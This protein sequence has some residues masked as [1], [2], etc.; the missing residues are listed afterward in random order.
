MVLVAAIGAGLS[1]TA[2]ARELDYVHEEIE[3]EIK[4]KL[5][6]IVEARVADAIA[7]QVSARI[8]RA[9]EIDVDTTLEIELE[10]PTVADDE[11]VTG[12]QPAIAPPPAPVIRQKT[13]VRGKLHPDALLPEIDLV[14][15]DRVTERQFDAIEDELEFALDLI[16]DDEGNSAI[17]EQWLVLSDKPSLQALE[18]QGYIVSNLEELDGLGYVLGVI[19]APGTFDPA[20]D[21]AAAVQILNSLT[22]AVD[23]NHVYMPQRGAPGPLKSFPASIADYET[24]IKPAWPRVGM[25]DSNIDATHPVFNS[26][27]ISEETFIPK[28][29][30]NTTQHGTAIASILI[31]DSSDYRG[32]TPASELFN[33]AVFTTDEHGNEFSTTAAI[34]RAINWLVEQ[35]VMLVNMSFAG[36]DNAILARVI[37]SAC[38]KGTTLVTSVGNS[39]PAAPPLYPAGYDCTIAVT[40]VDNDG[41]TYHRA[42]RGAHVDF[43]APGVDILH[44]QA[45]S[46]YGTSS[47]T[48]YAAAILSGIV[49]TQIAHASMSPS[50]IRRKLIKVSQDRGAIGR[51]RPASLSTGQ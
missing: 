26:A 48:S 5:A 35:N 4:E 1:G 20:V 29:F 12:F 28:G 30:E 6:A 17:S 45:G 10:G 18:S 24:V 19:S 21:G 27:K 7:D 46:G 41:F 39:G 14:I 38:A 11:P 50:E 16:I 33:G 36:P 51:D 49:A 40:A 13:E 42:N 37:E 32:F 43:A 15:A 23:L 47:G 8:H 25:I 3:L 34:V 9:I 44:A 22:V 31:G 2:T